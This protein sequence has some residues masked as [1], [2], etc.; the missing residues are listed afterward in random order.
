M[1][2]P[3]CHL[4]CSGAGA[5]LALFL[6]PERGTGSKARAPEARRDLRAHAATPSHDV[7]SYST[8]G[9]RP[10]LNR[11]DTTV[12]ARHI[13]IK[14]KTSERRHQ[15][16]TNAT[17]GVPVKT[18]GT[19]TSPQMHSVVINRINRL[20]CNVTNPQIHSWL[21]TITTMLRPRGAISM[22]GIS[23]SIHWIMGSLD[24]ASICLTSTRPCR[25][26]ELASRRDTM[27][28]CARC[29]P[30]Q[31]FVKELCFSWK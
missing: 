15:R 16:L 24:T 22:Y 25:C 2:G 9:T 10:A 23:G 14:H 3:S 4:L 7:E 21:I 12:R 19:R 26:P 11:D 20:L 17:A 1:S 29:L 31:S 30:Q 28:L 5:M 13:P 27:I 18:T 8:G 6:E